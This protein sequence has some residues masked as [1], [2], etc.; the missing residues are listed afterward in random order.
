MATKNLTKGGDGALSVSGLGKA[1]VIDN[2]IDFSKDG[3][4][5]LDVGQVLNIPA[6]TF[7]LRAGWD[8]LVPEGA[9]A[10]GTFG[11]GVDPDG[12][13][14]TFNGNA[15]AGTQVLSAGVTVGYALGKHY[16]TADTLDLVAT[17][18]MEVGT[19]RFFAICF[20]LN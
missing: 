14:A 4:A 10:A 12:F 19:V 6:G 5:A 8:V 15:A 3:L 11:D 2:V 18:G 1:F 13:H 20:D 16:T 7:V 9:T 17:D